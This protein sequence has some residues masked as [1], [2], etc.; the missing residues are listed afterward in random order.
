[1]QQIAAQKFAEQQAANQQLGQIYASA[2][3]PGTV[4]V[5]PAM[6]AN[7]IA[8]GADPAAVL[9][10]GRVFAT[11]HGGV[12]SPLNAR[13]ATA[14]NNFD[15]TPL[16]QTRANDATMDRQK[17]SEAAA[18]ARQIQAQQNAQA[19]AT[20]TYTNY[21][22]TDAA[23][24]HTGV[25]VDHMTDA[26]THA[27][28]PPN[29]VDAGAASI[30]GAATPDAKNYQ[31]QGPD[32]KTVAGRTLD[33]K[34]DMT[35][36]V[37]LP[38]NAVLS[39]AAPFS[40]PTTPD[41]KNYQF[42]GP[43]GKP[44]YGRTLDGKTDMTTGVALPPNA[45]LSSAAPI[46]AGGSLDPAA[47]ALIAQRIAQG[48]PQAIV[49]ARS[50]G[51]AGLAA[52]YN[53]VAR[54]GGPDA[55]TAA[56]KL[57]E[58]KMDYTNA[59]AAA[60]TTGALQGKM[61]TY[62]SEA[63]QLGGLAIIAS[64]AVP[65]ANFMPLAQLQQMGQAAMNDPNYSRL[66]AATNGLVNAYAKAINP[67]GVGTVEDKNRAYG[68]LSTAKNPE[69]YQATVM[70]MM[71]E[72]EA[73][74]NAPRNARAAERAGTA[75]TLGAPGVVAPAAEAAP[76]VPAQSPTRV[77]NTVKTPEDVKALPS[78]TRFLI[79]DGSGRIGVAP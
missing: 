15:T 44:V 57:I 71:Q 20:P 29:A 50:L 68:M 24:P 74:H 36:G 30:A 3:N 70:Q 76:A 23:G 63:A 26:R 35:T 55:A 60:Q 34:T 22:Y 8:H 9:T 7:A 75:G 28:L 38:A 77:V 14:T 52:I 59:H 56:Q 49:A 37:A 33:G 5:D 51:Q 78:G 53:E 39:S 16:Y 31:F 18:L 32:G 6:G 21:T 40:T 58:N 54:I 48:D 27:P 69:A 72:I 43:D 19:T 45:L 42:Q 62:G 4:G 10:M 67:N 11:T 41:A 61:D 1:M 73:A 17:V 79:P 65:R 25:T 66:V 64:N 2:M 46:A 47:V 13:I 12:D